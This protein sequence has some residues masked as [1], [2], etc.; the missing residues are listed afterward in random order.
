[1]STTT[2]CIECGVRPQIGHR[3]TGHDPELC[4]ECSI[5]MQLEGRYGI[6]DTDHLC[7]RCQKRPRLQGRGD[8]DDSTLCA[9]C[10]REVRKKYHLSIR[11]D[12]Y[13]CPKCLKRP[14]KAGTKGKSGSQ[15][16]C[17]VC[18]RTSRLRRELFV[19]NQVGKSLSIR[20]GQLRLMEVATENRT[21]RIRRSTRGGRPST[22]TIVEQ[23]RLFGQEVA[24]YAVE[25]QTTRKE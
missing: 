4:Y 15:L 13:F 14:R 10:T 19:A 8:G 16:L 1:M 5:R 7:V 23:M 9:E 3:K 18:E 25:V 20:E 11:S 24:L 22:Y 12:E 6:D 21:K 2:M 17:E